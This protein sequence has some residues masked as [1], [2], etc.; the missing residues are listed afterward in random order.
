MDSRGS[1]TKVAERREYDTESF[2][3]EVNAAIDAVLPSEDPLDAPDFD[4]VAFIN[5][6]FPDENSLEGVGT[7]AQ[8]IEAR[9]SGL[10]RDIYQAIR[11]QAVSGK[12]ASQGIADC[13]VAIRELF[14]KIT[15]IKGKA[16]DSEKM[17]DEICRDIRQLDAAKKN[18]ETSI[19]ALKRLQMLVRLCVCG[20]VGFGVRTHALPRARSGHFFCAAVA[21]VDAL[22]RLGVDHLFVMPGYVRVCVFC[23]FF[24]LLLCVCAC[25]RVRARARALIDHVYQS[26]ERHGGRWPLRTSR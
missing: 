17:V 22:Y 5:A 6:K 23:S 1:E 18:L 16:Q 19:T 7:Y 13:K 25:V 9:I 15:D 26:L 11:D 21:N 8:E 2:S 20:W 10:D 14:N 24:S 4:P 12:Q 3:E